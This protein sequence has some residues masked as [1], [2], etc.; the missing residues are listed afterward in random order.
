MTRDDINTSHIL[1]CSNLEALAMIQHA[2]IRIKGPPL[3][4][5]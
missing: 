4:P 5:Y 1:N 3:K 2:H